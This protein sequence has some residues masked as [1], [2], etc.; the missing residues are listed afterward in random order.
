M[1]KLLQCLAV[2]LACVVGTAQAA[3]PSEVVAQATR[4]FFAG[5]GAALQTLSANSTAWTTSKNG[6]ELQAAAFVQFRLA[7]WAVSRN[8]TSALKAAGE[9]CVA[10]TAAA[11]TIEPKRAEGYALQS[12]CY[13]YLATL[14]GFG[15]ISNGRKS[16][17]AMSAALALDP[18]N[19]RVVLVDAISYTFRPRI[20]GGDKAKAYARAQEAA[21][22]FDTNKSG[23]GLFAGWGAAEAWYWVGRGAEH[24]GDAATARQAYERALALEPAFAAARRKLANR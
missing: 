23:L 17:K 12:A 2:L 18:Q 6:D 7:Q 4:A 16:G 5:D 9:R 24:A 19:P 14:G 1:P 20:A 11:V 3:T 13:G 10:L 15:A 22:L 21:K 8:D